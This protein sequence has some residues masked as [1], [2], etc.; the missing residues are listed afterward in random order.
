MIRW[1]ESTWYSRIIGIV[2]F[3][4]VLPVVC[5]YLG[6]QFR[7]TL[8]VLTESGASGI[9]TPT[10]SWVR[11]FNYKEFI[12]EKQVMNTCENG[13]LSGTLNADGTSTLT[14]LKEGIKN[15]A[16]ADKPVAWTIHGNRFGLAMGDEVVYEAYMVPV[17]FPSGGKGA[18]ILV[19]RKLISGTGCGVVIGTTKAAIEH[20]TH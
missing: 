15:P 1:N 12:P 19:D 3:L 14:P 13:G 6:Y 17:A 10:R 7:D 2:V 20:Y 16:N 8:Q 9:S 18:T 11:D 5:F 4:L